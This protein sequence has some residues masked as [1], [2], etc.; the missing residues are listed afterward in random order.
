MRLS[1]GEQFGPYEI[2]D[3]LGAGGMG[4]V[5]RA[6]DPRLNRVV[7]IKLLPSDRVADE[8]N[9]RRFL[10][11][12][13]VASGL[14]NAHIVSIYDLC[15]DRG[16]DGIVMEYVPGR[17]LDDLVRGHRLPLKSALK[18]AIQIAD[19]LA[20]AH[21]AGIIH[22]DL[23]PA[24]IVIADDGTVKLLDFG[25][26]KLT[27]RAKDP[28]A[29]L[30]ERPLTDPGTIVGTV[31][32]MSPEQIEGKP[33]DARSDVFSFG[34]VLY[35]AVTG[36][37]A[38]QGHSKPST[39]SAVLR[40]QPP[41]LSADGGV[42]RELESLIHRCLRKDP[43]RR[44]QSMRDVKVILED[45][46]EESESGVTATRAQASGVRS[47][48]IVMAG[49]AVLILLVASAVATLKWHSPSASSN[50]GIVPFTSDVGLQGWPTFSPD[51]SQI[52]FWWNGP[53]QDNSD[54]Y[55][56]A[57]GTG[58][59]LRLTTHPGRDLYP[60]W[61][62]DGKYIAFARRVDSATTELLLI[63]P[64]G[65]AEKKIAEFATVEGLDWEPDS[66]RL[67]VSASTVSAEPSRLIE[68]WIDSDQRRDITIPT[69]GDS[70]PAV[71]PD[72]KSVAFYRQLAD[73]FGQIFVAKL[74]HAGSEVDIR[75][76]TNFQDGANGGQGQAACRPAWRPDGRTVLFARAGMNR[77][78]WEADIHGRSEPR[79]LGFGERSNSVAISR[80]G[81]RVAYAFAYTDSSIYRLDLRNPSSVLG[82]IAPSANI[83]YS[84]Q[85][86]PDGTKL[87]FES[88]RAGTVRLWMS[89]IDGSDPVLFGS[90]KLRT[91][92]S[93]HWSPDGT[94][95]A[96]DGRTEPDPRQIFV[97][98]ADGRSIRQLTPASKF[99]NVV[100]TWSRD[101]KWIYFSSNRTGRFE[102]WKMP[103][104]G[105][106]PVQVTRNGG[107]F[108]QESPDG[109]TL[110]FSRSQQSP[111]ELWKSPVAGGHEMKILDGIYNRGWTI[112]R[113][114]IYF[115]EL[116]QQG[117]IIRRLTIADGRVTDLYRMI[118]RAQN[119][120]ALSNDEG[121]LY[122]GQFDR[123]ATT[124]DLVEGFH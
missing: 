61:S 12:A 36:R 17:T 82:P 94:M 43:D 76:I 72:G 4:E 97:S 78:I 37:R 29:T 53:A 113:S 25:L 48:R 123:S 95:L 50:P 16:S 87:I 74:D 63:S 83:D 34:A 69:L 85:P 86:S 35:E 92:G 56:K 108:G 24:N 5:Y 77:G 49:A 57:I 117:S 80:R 19:A 120:I 88:S 99:D 109:A 7:A 44:I 119:E 66:K 14:R 73:L 30:T 118:G 107:W 90:D 106:E 10:Q 47:S 93:A 31:P 51:G 2:V 75:Q 104:T 112:G 3:R 33:L 22:R 114:A 91:T 54:I 11:E 71:S 1:S 122:F 102:V 79:R 15:S 8:D 18:Y 45:L 96:F 20:A 55:V 59:Q 105:G 41:P 115:I 32:Y 39:M 6:R 116:R 124:I 46:K 68:V 52:A 23:K 103:Q 81:D 67:I 27:E 111:T 110:Y 64:L 98:N 121:Y 65:G 58:S 42:P 28:N 26:A 89:N 21:A 70:L 100:P 9:R 38:F 84:P 40:D 62:P 13:Q 60:A 101:G